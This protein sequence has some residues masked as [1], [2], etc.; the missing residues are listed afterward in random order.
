MTAGV[1]AAAGVPRFS[2]DGT[3][4][5]FRSRVASIN[6][7]VIPLNAATLQAGT[8]SLLD[9]SHNVRIASDASPDG[10]LVTYYNIGEPQEDLFV[11]P[12]RGGPIR[13]VLDDPARDRG[14]VFMPDGRS[15]VFYSNRSGKWE[16]WTIDIDGGGLRKL[17]DSP[18][19]R[20]L[21]ACLAE[22]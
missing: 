16:I 1:H 7:V 17:T 11:G 14:P 4:L 13:R 22:G 2:R 19:G 20:R 5:A 10:N 6:P 9:A 3:R 8:P 12:A 21:P 15:L 18:E